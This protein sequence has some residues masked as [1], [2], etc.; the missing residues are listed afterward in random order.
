MEQTAK[1]QLQTG[2]LDRKVEEMGEEYDYVFDESVQIQFMADM[3]DR[4][5]GTMSGKDA[6]LQA[7]IDEAQARG[8]SA[9]LSLI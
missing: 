8:A 1:A 6:A 4:I 7:Q 5:E 9:L 3:E 2:A